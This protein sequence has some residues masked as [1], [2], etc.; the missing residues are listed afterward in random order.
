MSTLKELTPRQVL[1]FVYQQHLINIK[2]Y[3]KYKKITEII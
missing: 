3:T 2:V 1:I